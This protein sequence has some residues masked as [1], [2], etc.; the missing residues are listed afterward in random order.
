MLQIYESITCIFIG[1]YGRHWRWRHKSVGGTQV[2]FTTWWTNKWAWLTWTLWTLNAR[3]TLTE[4]RLCMHVNW[5]LVQKG[6][7]VIMT[8]KRELGLLH[9]E[10]HAHCGGFINYPRTLRGTANILKC[11]CANRTH[12]YLYL[13]TPSHDRYWPYLLVNTYHVM[14]YTYGSCL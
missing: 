14:E 9:N 13:Y 12:R 7:I 8:Q 3:R 5:Q 4:C 6:F 10:A 11:N 2:V 1:Q